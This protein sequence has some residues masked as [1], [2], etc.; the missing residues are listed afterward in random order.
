MESAISELT[1]YLSRRLGSGKLITVEQGRL[2]IRIED[3]VLTLTVDLD[4]LL[5]LTTKKREQLVRE[6]NAV[7][8]RLYKVR[9]RL[10][11]LLEE[12]RVPELVRYTRCKLFGGRPGFA[13]VARERR[14]GVSL[15]KV[16][17]DKGR[18]RWQKIEDSINPYAWSLFQDTLQELLELKEELRKLEDRIRNLEDPLVSVA[19]LLSAVRNALLMLSA[20][21]TQVEEEE[22]TLFSEEDP[23]YEELLELELMLLKAKRRRG[24]SKMRHNLN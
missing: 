22:A 8:D 13:I 20:G 1:E 3:Q 7:L 2:K 9:R 14:E 6:R 21:A 18:K 16:T 12:L 24:A 15:F 5:H 23:M 11:E 10:L 17:S 19:D 4:K